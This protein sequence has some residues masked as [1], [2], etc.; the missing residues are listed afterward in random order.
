MAGWTW[1][2]TATGVTRTGLSLTEG[3]TY[4]FSVKAMNGAGLWSAVGSSDGIT[5]D[6][7]PPSTPVVTDDGVY[8]TSNSSLHASWISTDPHVPIVGYQYAIGSTPGGVDVVGWTSVG[9]AAQVTATGLTLAT[10]LTYYFSVKAVNAAGL[11]SAVGGSDGITVDTTPPTTPVVVD[12]GNYTASTSTLHATWR[13]TDPE[14]GIANYEYAIGTSPGAA[15]VVGWTS[16]GTA[17]QVTRTDLS[18]V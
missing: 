4:Y 8:T 7:T 13:S 6:R 3:V 1:A 10:G 15:D 2:G 14:S 17:I 11:W 9:T 5:D 16:A 18:L 12:D